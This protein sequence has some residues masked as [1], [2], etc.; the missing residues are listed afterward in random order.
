M[1]HLSM[2]S[3]GR[4]HL[5]ITGLVLGLLLGLAGCANSF[6][7]AATPTVTPGNSGK[8]TIYSSMSEAQTTAYL[9]LFNTTY[10]RIQVDLV[11]L[12]T[13]DIY[14][15]LLDEQADPQA[16]VVWGLSATMMA[17]LQW[18]DVLYPYAPVGVKRIYAQFQDSDNP[19]YWVGFGAWMSAFCVNP[20][21]LAQAQ[22]P[23]PTS[24]A[25]LFDPI[26]A[27]Q[28]VMPSP[29][30]SGTG[31]MITEAI[32]EFYGPVL[33][34]EN[35]DAL[36]K[37]VKGYTVS[38]YQPCQMV[39]DGEAAIGVS[40][41]VAPIQLAAAGQPV[42]AVF[43]TEGAGWDIEANGLVRKDEIK[44]TAKLF[45]D[46]AIS[47]EAMK[48][49]GESRALLAMP[50]AEHQ[51]PAGF[52]EDPL[53]LIFDKDFPWASANRDQIVTEWLKRYGDKTQGQ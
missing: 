44:E 39:A 43:A 28:I 42:E 51:I 52:P 30:A 23:T 35:L 47:D 9:A 1:I 20:D 4:R 32:L 38:S 10:P 48:A 12:P 53:T 14:Q 3:R 41:D 5:A 8:L 29:A 34:W 37:N 19:P 17:L 50:L 11:S 13:A 26:Y 46:W 2:R 18:Q 6:N 36:D 21:L 7:R 24:W 33:G 25:S 27:D 22:L 49:Y 40:F 45:L 31:Y 15:R 16:D